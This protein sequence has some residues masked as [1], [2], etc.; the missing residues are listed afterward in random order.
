V[1]SGAGTSVIQATVIA[2]GHVIEGAMLS[3]TVMVCVQ[4]VVLLHE[5]A[6]WYVLVMILGQLPLQTS[7][8]KVTVGVPQLSEEIT[9]VI[10]GAGTSVMQATVILF[11]QVIVGAMLSL[12]V[13]VCVHVVVLPQESAAW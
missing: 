5:S 13:M 1:I 9:C 6:A 11:R 2:A 12:T 7:L 4:V 8:T 10:S 3:L